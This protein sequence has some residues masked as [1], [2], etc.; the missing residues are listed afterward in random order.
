MTHRGAVGPD[1]RD[2]DGAGVMTSI[3]HKFFVKNFE[4]EVD[5]KRYAR[6]EKV[7]GG[8]IEDSRVLD[9]VDELVQSI[10]HLGSS[11]RGRSVLKGLIT[12]NITID[13]RVRHDSQQRATRS[14]VR[15]RVR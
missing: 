10:A 1:A 4:R 2:G 12:I 8:E 3:P 6:V 5:I 9:G 7:P 14:E 11:D 13:V 15:S